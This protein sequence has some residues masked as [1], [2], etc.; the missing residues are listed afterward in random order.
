MKKIR[1]IILH[2]LAATL[3]SILV[4]FVFYH[5]AVFQPRYAA[6]QFVVIGASIGLLL[7]CARFLPP[8]AFLVMPVVVWAL[9]FASGTLTHWA[10]AAAGCGV[11]AWYLCGSVWS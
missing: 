6:F 5:L 3:G 4:G 8:K 7:G 1:I 9:Q 2:V 11:R 10:P